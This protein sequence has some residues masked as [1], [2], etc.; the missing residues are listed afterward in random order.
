MDHSIN[1]RVFEAQGYHY[2]RNYMINYMLF[3]L[4]SVISDSISFLIKFTWDFSI[5]KIISKGIHWWMIVVWKNI[6]FFY[7]YPNLNSLTK[8]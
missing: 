3:E 6:S 8:L 2:D 1:L 4:Y 5:F 7:R